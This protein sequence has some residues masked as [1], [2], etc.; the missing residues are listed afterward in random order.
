[1]NDTYLLKG[2]IGKGL[3]LFALPVLF[4]Q[5]FQ[6]LYN[7]ADTILVGYFLGE[8]ALAAMGA[9]AAVFELIV[10]FCTGC[11]NGFAI[12][13][14]QK[15]GAGD[16]QG[17]RRTVAMAFFW[18]LVIGVILTIFFSLFIPVLLEMLN[19]NPEIFQD[20]LHYI[21]IIIAGLVITIFYNF[22]AGMLRAIGD[23]VT[24]LVILAMSAVLN[25]GLDCLMILNFRLGVAGTA[26]ATLISQ[27]L[28][29]VVCLV[30]ILKKR[31]MLVP[32]KKDCQFDSGL[33][34]GLLEQGL[35]MGLMSSIVSIGTVI[36]QSAINLM[37]LN[38]QAAHAAVRKMMSIFVLVPGALFTALSAFT[39]Q[40]TGAGQYE[41]IVRG[42]RMGNRFSLVYCALL[43]LFAF[44]CSEMMVRL[45]S[46]SAQPEV[47]ANGALYLKIN[48]PFYFALSI[49]CTLRSCLQ[50]L[51]EKVVPVMSS[52]IELAGKLVFTW[53]VIPHT[54]YVGV[55]WSEPVIWVLMMLYLAWNYK[56]TRCLQG[57][58][59][60]ILL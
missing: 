30:W 53:L 17:L 2:S 46:G 28:C 13:A 24:P 39:A 40:N 25:I 16:R 31:R 44:T 21:R 19:T 7:T 10:G 4:S 43:T 50:A 38:I 54:G 6:T 37:S 60:K 52:V 58:N 11:G 12:V 22:E 8:H 23:S 59:P 3:L 15:F 42:I 35:A 14:G 9:V 20:S 55:C 48:L 47:I 36:L 5:L 41:R 1:M 29:S 18:S 27:G 56:R 32:E 26:Y 33:S 45:F 34:K 49:L 51:G 57:C